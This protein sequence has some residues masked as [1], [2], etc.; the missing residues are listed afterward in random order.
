MSRFNVWTADRPPE[1]DRRDDRTWEIAADTDSPGPPGR[2]GSIPAAAM[3]RSAIHVRP[4]DLDVVFVAYDNGVPTPDKLRL[5]LHKAI[6]DFVGDFP[7][8]LLVDAVMHTAV[9]DEV[10]ILKIESI[11]RHLETQPAQDELGSEQRGGEL[12]H[13]DR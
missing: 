6:G 11:K 4:I 5:D 10:M 13:I 12:R 9:G 7:G 3:N 1:Y 2:A 8:V